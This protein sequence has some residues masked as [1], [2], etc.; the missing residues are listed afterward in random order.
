MSLLHASQD[1]Q[2]AMAKPCYKLRTSLLGHSSDVRAIATFADGTIV[3]TSRD[4]TARVWKPSGIEKDYETTAT[5]KGHSNFVTSVCIINPSEQNPSGLIITGSH[6]KTICVYIL[7][8]TEPVNV[9]KSHQDTV[10]KLRTGI[11][12]GT[13]LSS[14]WDM[15]AKL[16]NLSDLSK[17]QLDLLEHTAAVWC[18]ADMA[19]GFI[20]TGGADKLVIVWTCD[21][22][23]KHKLTGHTDCVRDIST[24][25]S[26][27]FLTCGNDASIRHWDALAGT[28]LGTYYGHENYIYSIL[29]L[30]NGTSIFTCGEDRTLR[31]W[32]ATEL[33]ISQTI[34]L[35]TQ[36]VWCLALLPNGDVVTGSSDAVIR[37]FTCDPER[38]AEPEAIQEFEQ[39]AENLKLNAQLELGGI[40]INDLPDE[41]VLLEPGQKDGQT[42]IVNDKGSVMAYSWS[43][44][45]QKW[46][47][48]GNVMGASGGSGA[49]SGKQLYNG[50]EY[51]YVFS[52][53][54]QD[55]VPPLKL[56]YNKDDDPWH[57]AQKFLHDNGLSQLFLEQVANFIVK[58]SQSTSVMKTDAQYADPFTGGNRY[59][60][61]STGNA[62]TQDP[63]RPVSS[64]SSNSSTSSY[65][66]H[67]KY[68]KLEQA[69]LVQILE[70]LKEFNGKQSDSLRVSEDKLESL[71]KLADQTPKQ[72]TTDT[73]S[74]LRMLL[75]WPSEVLFPVLDI[76]RLAVLSKDVNDVLCTDELLQ[77]VKK[78][79]KPNALPSNQMLTFRLLANMFSHERGEKLCINCKDEILTLLSELK[80][81]TNKNNQVAVSTYILNLTVALNKYDD[82]RG[83]TQC[84]NAMFSVLPLLNEPEAMF[85]TLVA[86]GTLLST[87]PNSDDQ[88]GLITAVRQSEVA[89]DILHTMSETTVPTNKLANCSREIIRLII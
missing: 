10:C 21:G 22:S 57:V 85:R 66:P 23:V 32:N 83:K 26:N 41:K 44:D 61:Q 71:V 35:P 53:D 86:L 65:I 17:P 82:T 76:T 25:S 15:S 80:S 38:Y 40:K 50:K 49:T 67:T 84:L 27:E 4:K 19:S 1:Y 33:D 45:K 89:L 72:L 34:T 88:N 81:L 52:V 54:I 16:W 55:G 64:N 13:F 75:N 30:E 7:D 59:I 63:V 58:N 8:Q 79:L 14:S 18:V 43:Q 37:I 3:S 2:S 69:N 20:I 70:K 56:P 74:I 36:S 60:P 78:H 48:I 31:I 87:T 11:M 73:L 28:C 9:I 77:I 42:K 5:L 12:E 68:L 6:D 39:M 51:D 46:I 62:S 24:I 47:K 29:A